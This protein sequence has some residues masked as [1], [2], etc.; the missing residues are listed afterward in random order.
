MVLAL[1]IN[2]PN[3]YYVFLKQL[4]LITSSLSKHIWR[5]DEIICI[6]QFLSMLLN[7]RSFDS[8]LPPIKS[9]IFGARQAK[10]STLSMFFVFK[11]QLFLER[12]CSFLHNARVL[13]TKS[14]EVNEQTKFGISKQSGET[15]PSELY[16]HIFRSILRNMNAEGYEY[17]PMGTWHTHLS[18]MFS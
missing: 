6:T 16:S 8:T 2:R 17:L 7:P 4:L 13:V 14:T 9:S 15:P 18:P 1:N 12:W 11:K 3:R 10:S 5:E